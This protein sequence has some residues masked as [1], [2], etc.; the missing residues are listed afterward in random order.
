[1]LNVSYHEVA[2]GAKQC[3]CLQLGGA[4]L[5]WKSNTANVNGN[6]DQIQDNPAPGTV[7]VGS[8]LQDQLPDELKIT[9]AACVPWAHGTHAA[10]VIFSS[11]G[12]WSCR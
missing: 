4:N 10:F 3:S 5:F 11:S 6:I 9:N 1:M 8:Y 7:E 12:S 2:E